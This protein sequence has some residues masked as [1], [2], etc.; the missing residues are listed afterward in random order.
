MLAGGF[1]LIGSANVISI[2]SLIISFPIGILATKRLVKSPGVSPVT[3]YG[4]K[5]ED[6]G[7]G[8]GEVGNETADAGQPPAQNHPHV[9]ETTQLM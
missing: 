6:G 5:I 4:G 2:I 9:V 3:T 7:L 1:S 8:Q